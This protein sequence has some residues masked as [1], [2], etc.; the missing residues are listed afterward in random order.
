MKKQKEPSWLKIVRILVAALFLYSGFTKA[1]D[2]VA[3]AIQFDDYFVSFGMGFLH[4]ISMFC[5]V[6]MNIVEFTL[7]FMMLFRIR[8]DFTAIVYTLF[9][10]FFLL[11]TLWLFVAEYLEVNYGYNFHVVKDCGC[12]GKAIHLNNWQTF[13]KNI[14]IMIPV[15]VVLINRKLIPDI[16]LMPFGQ[17]SFALVGALLVSGFQLYCYQHLPI[18]DYSDWKKG[19]DVKEMFVGE[20]AQKEMLFVYTNN[21]NTTLVQIMTTEELMNITDIIPNFYDTYHYTDRLDTTVKEAIHPKIEGFTMVDSSGYE[22]AY[23]LIS[24]DNKKPLFLLFMH[25]LKEVDLDGLQSEKLKALIDYCKKENLDFIG[26]TNSLQA[27]ISIFRKVHDLDFPLYHNAIDPIKGPFIVRDAVRS[28]P[29]LILIKK[30]IVSE[31][32][33]WRDVP[34]ISTLSPL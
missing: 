15:I 1:V 30:G 22:H 3:A 10:A 17:W 23:E 33:S 31:K 4:P 18:V 7:G 25:N 5:A 32:W 9:M 28:N 26:I 19:K 11:L 12:F 6:M 16:R 2:P 14:V 27:E 20:P 34:E 8:V 24:Y 29:G 21:K 13:V